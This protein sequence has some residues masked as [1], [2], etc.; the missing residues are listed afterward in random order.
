MRQPMPRSRARMRAGKVGVALAERVNEP[1]LEQLGEALALLV[2][3][4]CVLVVVVRARKVDLLVRHVE[5]TAGHNGLVLGKPGEKV[6]VALV[7]HHALVQTGEAV[8]GVG[9]VHVDK[10]QVGELER[11]HAA[12]TRPS[13]SATGE[14][15]V[16]I[17]CSGSSRVNTAVPE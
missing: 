9:R 2:R 15:I 14:P 13:S 6:A 16:R 11:A 4:A 5:V 10:P 7:P 12:H 1:A 8:L 3:E 17:T